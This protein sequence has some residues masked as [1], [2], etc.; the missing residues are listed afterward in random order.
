MSIAVSVENRIQ[1]VDVSDE[2]ITAYL[3]DGPDIRRISNHSAVVF[4]LGYGTGQLFQKVA[5]VVSEPHDRYWLLVL[6]ALPS[7]FEVL[8]LTFEAML[9]GFEITLPPP[10]SPGPANVVLLGV[11]GALASAGIVAGVVAFLTIRRRR[12]GTLP[13]GIRP[14]A[15]PP[16]SAPA[17]RGASEP[18]QL[19]PSPAA[20]SSLA[21]LKCAAPQPAPGRFCVRCGSPMTSR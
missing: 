14:E 15:G 5:I 21:C 8:D 2:T 9:A 10:P 11:I 3:V 7:Q 4:V 18:P 13:V 19:A 6:T 16:V 12:I 20:A 17:Q 1:R